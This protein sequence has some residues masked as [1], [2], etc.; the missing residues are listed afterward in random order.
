MIYDADRIDV[1]GNTLNLIRDYPLV[2]SGGGSFHLAFMRYRDPALVKYYDHAHQDYL[3][4]MA[5]TGA[6]GFGLLGMVVLLSLGAA[7]RA[8]FVRRDALMRGMAFA[9]VMGTVALLIH[10]TVDF[11]LQIPANAATFM[12]ML[13]FGWIALHLDRHGGKRT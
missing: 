12:V 6:V 9:S 13:A 10:G 8:L 1:G 3:E 2:G 5:D 4:I 7:V 11:N